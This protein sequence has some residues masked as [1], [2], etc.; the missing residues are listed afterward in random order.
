[1][2][3]I[4]N[5]LSVILITFPFLQISAQNPDTLQTSSGKLLIKVVGHASIMFEYNQMI[6]HIDPYSRMG[7][8]KLMPK[9]DLILLTHHH[10]DHLDTAAIHLIHQN[11][12]HYIVAPVCAEK[13]SFK[14]PAV[15]ISNGEKMLFK[16][17]QI[18]AVPA[19]NILNKRESG[20]PYH[21]EGEGN[22][23]ILTFGDKRIYIAGDT[24]II[25]EMNQLGKIDVAFL[26]MNLPYTMSPEMTA[27]AAKVIQ[28][29]ILYPYHYSKTDLSILVG[30][31]N[32][33]KT[34]EVR[35]R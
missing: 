13:A 31:L 19:Y 25:P 5:I 16:D 8:Y 14:N 15:L 18:E 10:Q 30:L 4:L 3:L 24:E 21:P 6:I 1:M 29:V 20:V 12:T 22:G 27:E 32:D 35:I 2:K 28:P 34:I 9:A 11:N 23:Y 17:I 7:N 33:E 26:P